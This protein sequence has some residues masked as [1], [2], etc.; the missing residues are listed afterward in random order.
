MLEVKDLTKTFG[1]LTAVDDL[2]FT[3]KPGEIMGLIGQNGA[4]KTTT[5][6]IILNLLTPD[7]GHVLWNEG[8]LTTKTFNKIGYLPEERGLYP[9]V[10]VENQLL[11]FAQLRGKKK[12]EIKPLIDHWLEKFEV[13]GKKTDKVKT[14]SKGNQQKVQLIS[15][16]IH[17]PE[18]IILDEPFSGLD[19]VNAELLEDGIREAQANGASIIFSSHNMNNVEELCNSLIMLKD[20]KPVLNGTV[21]DIR[22]QFGRTKLFLESDLTP[23]ELRQFPGVQRVEKTNDGIDVAYLT[24]T[25]DGKA[26]FDAAT[27]NGYIPT[28]SQQ[29]P[30]LEEIFKRL[31]GEKNE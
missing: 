31:A 11:Y 20:G 19:P 30:T 23:E 24:E 9:K 27:K 25:E 14:L 29:P 28:F 17:Q 22:Q 3:I 10:S 16:L 2:N 12:S 8:Y 5:F 1:S 15:T 26:I 18:L 21:R 6:R 4:G 7:R 13:K